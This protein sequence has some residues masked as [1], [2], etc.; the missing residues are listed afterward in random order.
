M[1]RSTYF[2]IQIIWQFILSVFV[3]YFFFSN[4]TFD[5]FGNSSNDVAGI[6]MFGGSALY[7]VMMLVYLIIGAKKVKGWQWWMVFVSL[8]LSAVMAVAGIMALI[9]GSEFLY[10]IFK[11]NII[12]M[13]EMG[14]I[15]W[16]I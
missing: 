8:V 6:I 9:Y 7:F 13:K 16:Q 15:L 5:F 12:D 3:S 10:K 14:I 11:V 2:I 4:A 1:K